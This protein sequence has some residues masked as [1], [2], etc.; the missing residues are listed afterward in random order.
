MTR[1]R[2]SGSGEAGAREKRIRAVVD[3]GFTERQARFLGEGMRDEQGWHASDCQP[4]LDPRSPDSPTCENARKF[5]RGD[6]IQPLSRG[7][8]QRIDGPHS[9]QQH[10][11]VQEC[12]RPGASFDPVIDRHAECER[13]DTQWHQR[14][15]SGH[16][17][18]GE[19]PGPKFRM[20][21]TSIH[22]G[23]RSRAA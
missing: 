17:V 7:R 21:R 10:R 20:D 8:V 22:G 15:A 16:H 3:C 14:H 9:A 5:G 18:S 11:R 13:A 2:P 1:V 12:V 23:S 19:M 4:T 6:W